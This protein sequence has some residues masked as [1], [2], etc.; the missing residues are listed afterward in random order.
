MTV[1][2]Q[3]MLDAWKKAEEMETAPDAKKSWASLREGYKDNMEKFG[4]GIPGAHCIDSGSVGFWITIGTK[5]DIDPDIDFW[6]PLAKATTERTREGWCRPGAADPIT[7][8]NFDTNCGIGLPYTWYNVGVGDDVI[9]LTAVPKGGGGEIFGA[10][11]KTLVPLD[12]LDGI[13]KFVIDSTIRGGRYGRVCPPTIVG[14][15][16]GGVE[17]I[18]ARNALSAAV[19]RP[20]GSRH[21]VKWIAD[22][23]DELREDLNYLGIGPMGVG[24]NTTALDVN[25]EY[26][27]GHGSCMPVGYINQCFQI[28]RAT[29]VIH[30]NGTVDKKDWPV[31]WFKESRRTIKEYNN[32]KN[33]PNPKT[34]TISY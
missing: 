13:R 1:V 18:A 7:R 11:Y 34:Y 8:D 4:K 26:S 5:A 30:S 6:G 20:I 14:V 21:P 22:F 29:S 12:H 9:E 27:W 16:V 17:G 33:S 24:G 3:D 2:P 15:G 31:L 10:T 23:E 19:L 25:M 32:A 28:H